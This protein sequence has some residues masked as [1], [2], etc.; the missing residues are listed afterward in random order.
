MIWIRIVS[1]DGAPASALALGVPLAARFGES[2]GDLGRGVGCTL[3]LPDPD[4]A[5]SR[6]QA[7]VTKQNGRH[8]IRPIG[9]NLDIHLNGRQ[10]PADVESPL[11]IGAEIRIGPYLMRVE[12]TLNE[13]LPKAP[14]QAPAPA[15]PPPRGGDDPLEIFGGGNRPARG[16]VFD[17]LL[18]SSVLQPRAVGAPQQ[19]APPPRAPVAPSEK[20]SAP[21]AAPPSKAA[22]LAKADAVTLRAPPPPTPPV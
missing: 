10:L 17:D 9:A 11:E 22:P 16:G 14:P 19:V 21:A 6:K 2:I 15:P 18:K 20:P 12:R 13:S 5:I 4:R 3:V 8:F 1:K 7:L